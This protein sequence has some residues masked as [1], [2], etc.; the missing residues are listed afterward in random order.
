MKSA[1]SRLNSDKVVQIRR[2]GG[3]MD[4]VCKR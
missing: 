1:A 2:F 4:F 3:C